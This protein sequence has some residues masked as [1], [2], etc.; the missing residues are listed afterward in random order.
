MVIWPPPPQLSTWFMN[1]PFGCLYEDSLIGYMRFDGE[2]NL[3][4]LPSSSSAFLAS[5]AHRGSKATL[6][7]ISVLFWPLL[8]HRLLAIAALVIMTLLPWISDRGTWITLTIFA[9]QTLIVT[10]S[11]NSMPCQSTKLVVYKVTFSTFWDRKK[12]PKQYPEFRP[13][14]Q[15]SK[16]IGK[17]Y[18]VQY[19][20]RN[21]NLNS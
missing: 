1:D 2:K 17:I 16:L 21:L 18:V 9:I 12:F 7:F 14:A 8:V 3:A 19:H 4:T 10:G 13:P 15:W 6:N 20:A 11:S 5:R